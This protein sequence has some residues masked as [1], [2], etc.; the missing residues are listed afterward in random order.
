MMKIMD[1]VLDSLGLFE[2]N[3]DEKKRASEV[4]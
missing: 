4:Q 1:K 2:E 3:K